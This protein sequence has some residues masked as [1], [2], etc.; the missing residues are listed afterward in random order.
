MGY[1]ASGMA[2][3][4]LAGFR[5]RTG[6]CTVL[7]AMLE[8]VRSG[9]SAVLVIRGE[10]GVGKTALLRHAAERAAGFRVAPIGGVEAE[11][12]LPFAGL[13]QLCAPMLAHLGAIPPPQQAA[14]RVAFGLAAGPAPDRFLVALAALSLL[15]EVAEE[16]PL[17]C[18]VD[19][20]QW[21]DGASGQVLGF[22]ARR[23]LAESVGM[24]FAVREPSGERALV[25]LPELLVRGLQDDDARA[26]LETV[27]AGRLDEGVRDRLVFEARGNPLALLELPRGM[28]AADLAGGFALPDAGAL[29]THIE[30]QYVRRLRGLPEATQRLMLLAAAD[31]VGDATLF[32]R[33]AQALGIERAAAAPAA[34]D[35]LLEI[36]SRV[37][38][39]HPLVRSAVYRNSAASDRHAAHRALAAAT[40]PEADPDRRAWHRAHAA[41]A[42]D[43]DVAG[44]LVHRA[45]R[46]QRRGGIAAAAAFLERAVAL[47]PDPGERAVRALAAA[48][49]KFAAGDLASAEGLLATAAAGPLDDV[50]CAQVQHVSA[51]I[52]F[53]MRRGRDAL[54]LLLVAARR[55]EPLDSEL[56]AETYLEA[57][58]AAMYAGPLANAGDPAAI[59]A[60]ARAAPAG[61]KP[62]PAGR[63]LLLGLATRLIDGYAAAA[64]ALAEALRMH[65]REE[66]RLDWPSVAYLIAAQD[67]WDDRAWFEL[68][69]RQAELA[70]ST[71]TLS[72]LP[73]ALDYL[74]GNHIQAGELSVAAGL[75]TEALGLD[76]GIRPEGLSFIPLLLAAWRGREPA[77]LELVEVITRAADARGEGCAIAVAGYATAVLYNGLGRYEAAL[78]AAQSAIAP[79][80]I[81]TSSWALQELVEAAART[82]R[83]DVARA[84]VERLAARTGASGTDWARGTEARARALVADGAPQRTTTAGRSSCSAAPA[85]RHSSPAPG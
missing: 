13:H 74:A 17:L 19:D 72:L 73:W 48:R 61:A 23:L 25:G 56:A 67:L 58:I 82:G 21:L 30:A 49:A 10:A 31:P 39:R 43:E 41:A 34:T 24:V 78:A 20:A 83:L 27:I 7:D 45:S 11:M 63:L 36:G 46:A 44:E 60:A 77:A 12:E 79:D 3:E 35:R 50:G 84:A 85:W 57:L 47:T 16:G 28:S 9:Q 4:H 22:V 70:R 51:Q 68:A 64:P 37:R 26:L 59:A 76:A 15:C 14:M 62:A 75:L 54:P 40:D 69:S 8:D 55:L 38:F 80:D 66:P 65:Q 6:E 32:W 53:A 42:P 29:P 33:A 81:V 2:T 71:G 52:A 1:A 5:G 18:I